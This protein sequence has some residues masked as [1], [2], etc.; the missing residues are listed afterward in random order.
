M[1]SDR[2]IEF[3][4]LIGHSFGYRVSRLFPG[5]VLMIMIVN[6][7]KKLLIFIS[8]SGELFILL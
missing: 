4:F 1:E 7:I 3:K 8:P 6:I 5:I 2:M